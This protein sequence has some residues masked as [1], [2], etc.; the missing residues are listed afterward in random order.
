MK[1]AI[2]LFCV[3]VICMALLCGCTPTGSAETGEESGGLAAPAVEGYDPDHDKG[4]SYAYDTDV[5]RRERRL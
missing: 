2:S 3:L 4:E 1:K 5:R